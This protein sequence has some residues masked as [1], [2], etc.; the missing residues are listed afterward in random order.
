MN[1]V[2]YLASSVTDIGYDGIASGVEHLFAILQIQV[3]ACAW[4]KAVGALDETKGQIPL[5]L[6]PLY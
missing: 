5:M 6:C 2:G 4:D 1:G 3:G